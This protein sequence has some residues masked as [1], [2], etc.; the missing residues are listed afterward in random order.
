MTARCFEENIGF[1]YSSVC[2]VVHSTI[3]YDKNQHDI[4]FSAPLVTTKCVSEEA[5]KILSQKSTDPFRKTKTE[6]G[7]TRKGK[8]FN[9]ED[10]QQYKIKIEKAVDKD[11]ECHQKIV[12]K[13]YIETADFDYISAVNERKQK[14]GATK[15]VWISKNGAE[16]EIRTPEAKRQRF[17]RPPPYRTRL[18]RPV[19]T[20]MLLS[21]LG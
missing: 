18:P 12:K 9:I 16:E 19:P 7:F 5:S 15:H 17:S 11:D 2:G 13:G 4:L 3:K 1:S 14:R 10:G 21:I 6:I 20:L 8:A